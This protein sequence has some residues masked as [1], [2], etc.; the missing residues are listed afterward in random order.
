MLRLPAFELARPASLDAALELLAAH[1]ADALPIAGGTD[2]LP[3]MKHRLFEPKVLVSLQD[4]P[5]LRGV[6]RTADGDLV[7]GAMTRLADLAADEELAELAPGLVQAAGL[8]AGP[9]LRNAATLGGNVLLDT[10]CQ[11]YNQTYFWRQALGFCLKKDG[12]VCHVVEGGK[13][14]V[15]AASNDTAPALMT[16]DATLG[17]QGPDGRR[18]VAI[19]DLWRADGAANKDV[20]PG[21]LLVDVRLP[22]ARL[23]R[24]GAYGKLRDRASIDF[25][26]LGVAA[27]VDVEAGRLTDAALC[28]TALAARPLALDVAPLL[29]GAPTSGAEL[30]AA[31]AAAAALAHKR[32]RPLANIPGDDDWRRE[33]VPVFVR[34]TLRAALDGAGPVHGL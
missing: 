6:R 23:G 11:W 4:V 24:A 8:V 16:L 9:Q 12:T 3:N 10:R 13:K 21:E 14:C 32:C 27:R 30:D 17:F 1:G 33:M 15:A 7:L 29:V 19:A 22:A 5:E 34:R 2:L 20:A 31:L 26:L 25:P 18:E 28:V